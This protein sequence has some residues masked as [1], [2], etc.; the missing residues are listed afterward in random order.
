MPVAGS[1]TPDN[2]GTSQPL[3]YDVAPAF[4]RAATAQAQFDLAWTNMTAAQIRARA[5]FEHSPEYV[6]A[7]RELADAQSAYDGACEAVIADLLKDP[8]YHKLIEKRTQVQ[9]ALDQHPADSADVQAIAHLKMEYSAAASRMEADA[10]AGDSQVQ[11]AK[12]R[13]LAGQQ[14]VDSMIQRFED[15]FAN[16]PAVAFAWR[17]YQNA[18]VNQAGAQ[19]YLQG[20]LITRDDVNNV[21]YLRYSPAPNNVYCGAPYYPTWSYG[22]GINPYFFGYYGIVVRRF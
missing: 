18:I 21:N 2:R 9:I 15:A 13:L 10:L 19:G 8:A 3:V 22:C 12:T 20:A 16:Q 11:N 5:Q 7:Q 4:A 17:N 14:V 1:S 6:A